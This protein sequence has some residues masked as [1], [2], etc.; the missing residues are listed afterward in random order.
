[1]AGVRIGGAAPLP[2]I[3]AY[4]RLYFDGANSYD[5]VWAVPAAGGSPVQL[6]TRTADGDQ[7]TSPQVSRTGRNVAYISGTSFANYRLRAVTATGSGD[8]SL[9]SNT[10]LASPFWHPNGSKVLYRNGGAGFKTVNADGTGAAGITITPSLPTFTMLDAATYN[11]DGSLIA[12][13]WDDGDSGTVNKLYVM[14]ADGSGATAI[15]DGTANTGTTISSWSPVADRIA[16]FKKNGANQDFVACDA[17]GS[18]VTVLQASAVGGNMRQCW[19]S[20]GSTLVFIHNSPASNTVWT[21]Q[22]D[23]TGAGAISGSPRTHASGF[24][25][26]FIFYDRIYFVRRTTQDLVSTA[27][28]GSDLRVE[29][30]PDLVGPDFLDL[31]FL[32]GGGTGV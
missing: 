27:L 25:G 16:F 9:D 4:V 5:Q 31:R 17:D 11:S 2:A 10:G 1:M 26:P 13:S 12:F 22:S 32:D 24:T 23:G 15:S 29:D 14:N 30:T 7:D 8:I 3:V 19:S 20:D 28:D 18:N 21:V 6:T